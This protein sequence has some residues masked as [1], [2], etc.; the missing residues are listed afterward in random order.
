MSETRHTYI[1]AACVML[2]R[3][4][5]PGAAVA[6]RP[7]PAVKDYLKNTIGLDD[8]QMSDAQN[9]QVVVKLLHT[10]ISR[11]VIVFGIVGIHASRASYIVHLRDIQSLIAARSQQFGV[12]SDPTVP[13]DFQS[14]ALDGSEWKDL[15]HCRVNDCDFKMPESSM[16][17][18]AGDVNWEGSNA[19]RQADS[20]MR[21]QMMNLVAAYRSRGNSALLR[22]DDTKGVQASDAFLALLNQSSY[23]Q[24][25]APALRDYLINF[26]NGRPSG[27]LDV[28][29]WSVDRIP[30]LRPTFTLNQMV[31]YAP[32]SGEAMIARKQLYANHYFEAALELSTLFDA[33]DLNGGAG[34]YLVTIRRYRFDALP[35]GFLNIRGRARSQLQKLMKSDLERERKAVEGTA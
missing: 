27:A 23:M 4:I 22:Y 30:H 10:D 6:Q 18:F 11:D 12:I 35:G 31:V 25:Y 17:Q 5:V 15:R 1:I 13:A 3:V 9:G 29:Y 19:E 7:A 2:L 26:P 33:P 16:L 20:V 32:A 8:G 21:N 24:E 28:M 34:I 14:F